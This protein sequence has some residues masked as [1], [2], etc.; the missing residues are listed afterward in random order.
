MKTDSKHSGSLF[1]TSCFFKDYNSL[2]KLRFFRGSHH[3]L[4]QPDHSD[5][6]P[7]GVPVRGISGFIATVIMTMGIV[8][9]ATSCIFDRPYGDEFYRTLWKA[10]EVP[11]GP[12]DAS[13]ITLEFLCGGDV[14]L[15]TV[16][17]ARSAAGPSGYGRY[18]FD[19]DAATFSG[20]SLTYDAGS[21]QNGIEGLADYADDFGYSATAGTS[22][23]DGLGGSGGAAGADDD[24]GVDDISG[25]DTTSGTVTITFFEAHRNGD[26]LFL[27]W[28]VDGT[29]YQF[30]TAMRRLSAYE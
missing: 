23:K 21:I 8:S 22:G 15:K 29:K 19:G 17:A 4:R 3:G 9:T 30:T 26:T 5:A 24:T 25:S 13:S 12:F 14:V 6:H 28:R 7:A 20:L 18:A 10:D 27:I 2:N 1:G 16:S 11:L